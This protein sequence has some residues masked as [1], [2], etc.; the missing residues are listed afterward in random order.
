MQTPTNGQSTLSEDD[1]RDMGSDSD[2]PD[3]ISPV[4]MARLVSGMTTHK[5]EETLEMLQ[6][7]A[8]ENSGKPRANKILAVIKYV[9]PRKGKHFPTGESYKQRK[10]R[11]AADALMQKEIVRKLRKW[12]AVCRKARSA[13]GD[14]GSSDETPSPASTHDEQRSMEVN[15]G[16]GLPL[17]G[18]TEPSPK[19]ATPKHKAKP[20]KAVTKGDDEYEMDYYL[21]TPLERQEARE[22]KANGGR[23]RRRP[24]AQMG[25]YPP[26]HASD[27]PKMQNKLTST[28]S[29][30]LSNWICRDLADYD[31][32][33]SQFR[34][35]NPW[36]VPT[37]SKWVAPA[38]W[39]RISEDML[40][41]EDKTE[42]GPPNDVAVEAFLRSEGR[43]EGRR[44]HGGK[45]IQGNVKERLEALS[46]Q[47]KSSHI[48]AYEQYMD[49]W[50][51][52]V[53]T[54]RDCEKP[55]AKLTAKIILA[56]I[57]PEKL[58]K[59][60]VA[61][62]WDGLGPE[63]LSE[64][65]QKWRQLV[66]TDT[67]LLR[68]LIRENADYWDRMGLKKEFAN[69]GGSNSQTKSSE[70][71][72]ANNPE[73]KLAGCGN[74]VNAKRNGGGGFFQYCNDHRQHE[75]KNKSSGQEN[76]GTNNAQNRSASNDRDT[77]A[78]STL[79][80]LRPDPWGEQKV[81]EA[82]RKLIDMG[83][84]NAPSCDK[85]REFSLRGYAMPTC[86]SMECRQKWLDAGRPYSEP[87][88][89]RL[90]G[91][92]NHK[93]LECEHLSQEKI[94]KLT[95]SCEYENIFR[96]WSG[97]ANIIKA[98]KC[99]FGDAKPQ[100]MQSSS[101]TYKYAHGK[102]NVGPIQRPVYFDL[103][104]EY[105]LLDDLQYDEIIDAIRKGEAK[106]AEVITPEQLGHS[107]R[108]VPVDLACSTS[109]NG[110]S[111]AWVKRWIRITVEVTTKAGRKFILTQ[112]NIG[113]VRRSTPLLILGKKT[114]TLC[115]YRTIKQQDD[116][117]RD[118]DETRSK[119]T[120]YVSKKPV[121]TTMAGADS[122]ETVTTPASE[123]TECKDTLQIQMMHE[124]GKWMLGGQY[125]QIAAS[126][127]P[128]QCMSDCGSDCG[129]EFAGH[130]KGGSGQHDHDD[131]K[132][133]HQKMAKRL[134]KLRT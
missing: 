19:A 116:D 90:C 85:K 18:A 2:E 128:L 49:Q 113:F 84:C 54:L 26:M 101:A 98:R 17:S 29:V 38:T 64:S 120:N 12:D 55:S 65:F 74:K 112:A 102:A 22:A 95:E 25:M 86:I 59:R 68:N 105:D 67:R 126:D 63:Y 56:A 72:R 6:D 133:E 88:P 75:P 109:T 11:K 107:A 41:A 132:H 46:Y 44:A 10:A 134:R 57:K 115:G 34:L 9:A 36:Y 66:K 8:D 53:M 1:L 100:H 97:A 110:S 7:L 50:N 32:K 125:L 78:G 94:D 124:D 87:E 93:V 121:T 14:A 69:W 28:G 43:Y 77:V 31:R 39:V 73:C 30:A 20:S 83:K 91:S 48:Q 24:A 5:R 96:W 13:A 37:L 127:I 51:K 99:I 40:D 23:R 114:C 130:E 45:I 33:V 82:E 47:T 15:E 27:R 71:K 16:M 4:V 21:M 103:G 58:R 117:R 104:G 111:I 80:T 129:D 118:E 79:N 62:V 52:I 61:K 131:K 123:A 122:K 3:T 42:G 108:G 89:C 60:I 76:A 81:A 106:G 35:A 92:K 70:D 119:K